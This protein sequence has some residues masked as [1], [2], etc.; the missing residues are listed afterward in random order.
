MLVEFQY[1]V[2]SPPLG[3]IENYILEA[4][5]AFEELGHQWQVFSGPKLDPKVEL[6]EQSKIALW[7]HP[8]T[9]PKGLSLLWR[10]IAEY[11]TLCQYQKGIKRPQADLVIARHPIYAIS[12][13]VALGTKSHIVYLPG[14]DMTRRARSETI[15]SPR[16]RDRLFGRL[17][18][19][20][21]ARL[22]RRAI[23]S[24]NTF[25][26]LSKNMQNQMS[27]HS[28]RLALVNGAGVNLSK[29]SANKETR[30]KL[31]Q[32]LGIKENEVLIVTAARLSPEKNVAFGLQLL[33]KLEKHV[34]Y[35][36]LGT[37]DLRSSL[38]KL[39]QELSI[40]ERVTFTGLVPNPQDYYAASDLY[41]QPATEEPFGHVLL[42]AMA[43]ELPVAATANKGGKYRVATEELVPPDCGVHIDV[44]DPAKVCRELE[45]LLSSADERQQVGQRARKHIKQHH[46]WTKH[47]TM[48][49]DQKSR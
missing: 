7:R 45:G 36:V 13:K 21:W 17:F 41:L 42:E 1:P 16:W 33:A 25:M 40:T 9:R 22:E 46:S 39:A 14:V 31:R 44:D 43:S 30:E 37:G 15:G 23:G 27:S 48:I 12:A 24:A 4:G 11:R 20:Q 19:P 32:E 6:D 34:K 29:F 35:L 2:F 28:S 8:L 10:P 5:A 18:T 49:I 3:G 47:V 26:V 38:E